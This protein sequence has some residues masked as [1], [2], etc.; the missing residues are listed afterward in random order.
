MLEKWCDKHSGHQYSDMESRDQFLFLGFHKTTTKKKE[1]CIDQ[2]SNLQPKLS[3]Y[4]LNSSKSFLK[5]YFLCKCLTVKGYISLIFQSLS[6]DIQN[7]NK[8]SSIL[9]MIKPLLIKTIFAP[10]NINLIAFHIFFI[11]GWLSVSGTQ[12]NFQ[13]STVFPSISQKHIMVNTYIVFY[14]LLWR[15]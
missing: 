11:N 1:I 4:A 13:E 8:V 2:E 15:F 14:Y 3:I 9:S 12:P 10:Q 5:M 7:L 6:S